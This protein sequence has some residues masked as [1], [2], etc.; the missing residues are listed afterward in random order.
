MR[1]SVRRLATVGNK[2]CQ[3]DARNERR[4]RQCSLRTAH[5]Q[6]AVFLYNRWTKVITWV[7]SSSARTYK[8]ELAFIIYLALE[9]NILLIKLTNRGETVLQNVKNFRAPNLKWDMKRWIFVSVF[10]S[11]CS[12]D[13]MP[14]EPS[15][16]NGYE[17]R[18]RH[19]FLRALFITQQLLQLCEL[20]NRLK[21]VGYYTYGQ[22]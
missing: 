13:L 22:L 11:H 5:Q 2:I 7:W 15:Y 6:I 9:S 21:P 8:Y 1:P 12:S 14:V 10:I 4:Q 3:S 18:P 19:I 16:C 20:I 17:H